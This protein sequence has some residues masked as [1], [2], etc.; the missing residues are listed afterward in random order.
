[1][2]FLCMVCGK[3]DPDEFSLY[4][5]SLI[6]DECYSVFN[7][8]FKE[9]LKEFQADGAQ[10]HSVLEGLEQY[11][12]YKGDEYNENLRKERMKHGNF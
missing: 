1:M 10:E 6:C 4:N 3:T 2:S 12:S 7:Y 11:A 8:H 9:M 5:K